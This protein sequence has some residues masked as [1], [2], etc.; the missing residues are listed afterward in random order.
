MSYIPKVGEE[1]FVY[2]G[3]GNVKAT[4]LFV[5]KEVVVY[6]DKIGERVSEI[7]YCSPIK[8]PA[9]IERE[10]YI[11]KA[12]EVLGHNYSDDSVLKMLESL[13]DAGMLVN[14]KQQVKPLSKSY[15]IQE[16]GITGNNY[17]FMV[18]HGFIVQGGE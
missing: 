18:E 13:Y 16:I 1:C 15:A 10:K 17:W 6:S 7:K 2:D 12:L 14:P 9:E 4:P 8:T 5:G 3:L 11:T